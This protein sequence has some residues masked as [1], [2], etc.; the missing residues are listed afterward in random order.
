MAENKGFR[1][2]VPLD[3]SQVK[4]LKPERPVKVIAYGKGV[5]R[6]AIAK[7]DAEGKGTVA[8][9]FDEPPGTLNVAVG[10]ENASA[11]DL[12]NL[13]T[14]SVNV[15]ASRWNAGNALKLNPVVISSYYWNW[16]WRWCQTFKVTGRVLCADGSPVAGAT[17]CA[18]D[19]D[20]WWWWTSQ[21][22]VGCTTTDSTGS[23]EIDFTRCCGWWPW[24]WWL[25]R[26][27]Q[28]DAIVTSKIVDF[29][30]TNPKLGPIPTPSP[31]PSLDVFQQLLGSS[32]ASKRARPA[33]NVAAK[34][35]L[36][37][38]SSDIDPSVLDG[39]RSQ[40]LEI[41]PP[42]FPYPIWPWYPW[43]P[44]WDCGANLIFTVTQ[45]CGLQL[46]T[47]VNQT[48]ADTQWDVP[49]N[50]NVTL[51]TNSQAC[52][53]YSCSDCPDG[54]C[55][56][57]TDICDINVGSIGGNI[58][59]PVLPNPQPG[60][61]PPSQQ[62][63]LYNP[64]VEDRPFAGVVDLYGIFG[65][66]ADVD[67][68]EFQYATPTGP[69]QG[70]G[71]FAPLPLAALDGFS[72]LVLVPAPAPVFFQW[73]PIGFPVNTISDGTTNHYVI[74]T[75]AHYEANN[76][77][78]IWDSA[79]HDLLLPLNTQNVLS[80]GTYYLRLVGYTRPGYA[81]NLTLTNSGGPDPGVLLVC[82][83]DCNPKTGEGCV[84]NR[85]VVT[86]D[87]QAPGNTDPSGNPLY[88]NPAGCPSTAGL[89]CQPCGSGT[90]HACTNQPTT[91]IFNVQIV[92]ADNSIT[93][94]KTCGNVSI[95]CTDV[96]EVD[97]VAY[98]PDAFLYE[99]TLNV[100][101]SDNLSQ[102]LL[103][104]AGSTGITP[105]AITMPWA[106]APAQV[107]PDYST[108]LTQGAVSPFWAG[109]AITV[110]VNASQALPMTCAYLLQLIAYKRPIVDCD[111]HYDQYNVSEWSFTIQNNCNSGS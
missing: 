97:F 9:T 59:S 2:E 92:H 16:W 40:L 13:Q 58:G 57:P 109:G 72:R 91:D 105:G 64:G 7:L 24:Y 44:W 60:M 73:V 32:K 79:T 85:W 104:L 4:H 95:N 43:W 49:T 82:D 65:T 30:R 36:A 33:T 94:V 19:V 45:T 41:I 55:M 84:D 46:N 53:P 93:P 25:T 26:E 54:N 29:L 83:S 86:I 20:W 56:V 68:Y 70:P 62:E 101:Y 106:P 50:Y 23:F 74:E 47:I 28:L 1:L 38:A 81:G 66:G 8:F 98:D 108:A 42:E 15:P 3:A 12:K 34:S 99:Y 63:G 80:N 110:K 77:S 71:P 39:L 87:N 61:N 51:T 5:T 14:I 52:C 76:G 22:Q 48:I 31:K 102:D 11:Q 75:I 89:Y 10:P 78:Q 35:S 107:G 6:E 67:Y 100:Y 88:P 17:V 27:W 90:V 21:E 37:L 69:S 18:F 111:G 103:A 96:L